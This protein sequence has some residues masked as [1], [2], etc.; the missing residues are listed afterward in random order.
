MFDFHIANRLLD[1]IKK[2]KTMLALNVKVK[3]IASDELQKTFSLPKPLCKK[4][5]S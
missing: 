1:D 2:A 3:Y 5:L 4:R